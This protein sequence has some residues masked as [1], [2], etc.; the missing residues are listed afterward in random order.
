MFGSESDL[1]MHVQNLGVPSPKTR[2]QKLSIFGWI[3]DDNAT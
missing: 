1:K 2:G 3:Y